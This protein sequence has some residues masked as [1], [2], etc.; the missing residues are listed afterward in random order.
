MV[1]ACVCIEEGRPINGENESVKTFFLMFGGIAN[2][3]EEFF[4][5]EHAMRQAS[6]SSEFQMVEEISYC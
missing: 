3:K 1:C 6:Q 5:L 2:G 4:C